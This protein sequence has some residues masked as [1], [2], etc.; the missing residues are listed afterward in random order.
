M[1]INNALPLEAAVRL[2][3]RLHG[4]IMVEFF[5]IGQ[6]RSDPIWPFFLAGRRQNDRP[7]RI[8]QGLAIQK[9]RSQ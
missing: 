7:D 4:R 1:T 9:E 8:R 6:T 2:V 3:I 5:L